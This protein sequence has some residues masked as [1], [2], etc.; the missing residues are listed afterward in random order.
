M[1]KR[2]NHAKALLQW[3]AGEALNKGHKKWCFM[4]PGTLKL[5]EI[6]ISYA[7]HIQYIIEKIFQR[8]TDSCLETIVTVVFPTYLPALRCV[9]HQKT[10]TAITYCWWTKSCITNGIIIILGGA[11][12][13]PS[14]VSLIIRTSWICFGTLPGVGPPLA[15]LEEHLLPRPEGWCDYAVAAMQDMHVEHTRRIQIR[16]H[17]S[18]IYI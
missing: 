9:V 11:G 7:D 10:I 1:L 14:T 13:C 17:I 16:I 8:I 4:A 12:F 5:Y 15:T 6:V 2:S 18:Y 3:S